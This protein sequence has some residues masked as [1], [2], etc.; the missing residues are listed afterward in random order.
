MGQE[1]TVCNEA[2][3]RVLILT[4]S[5]LLFHIIKANLQRPHLRLKLRNPIPVAQSFEAAVNVVQ[6]ANDN[7]T[8]PFSE[9]DLIIVAH[10]AHTSEPIVTLAQAHLADQIGRIPI[11]IISDRPFDA[12]PVEQIYHLDFPFN[13]VELRYTVEDLLANG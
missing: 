5:D 6:T 1:T 10:S 2:L 4:D 12:K 8:D 13:S 11:L 7:Q 9:I 3:K